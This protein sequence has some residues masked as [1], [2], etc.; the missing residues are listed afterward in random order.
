[1]NTFGPPRLALVRGEGAHVWDEQGREY[2]DFFGGI[3]VN[4]LGHN[5]PAL[6]EAVTTQL[7]TL[8]HVSNFFTSGPQVELAERLL[9]LVAGDGRVFFSNSGT[10]AN[11]AAL[12]LTRRTGRTG[13]WRWRA[14]STAA[15]WAPWRS[16]RRLPTA[17]RSSRCPGTSRSCPTATRPRSLPPSTRPRRRSSS[18]RCR[19]RPAWSCRPPASCRPPR[20]TTA[21]HGALLWVDEVQTGMGRTGEWLAHTEAGIVPD[22]VTLAK[23]LGGG[24]PI[25]AMIALGGAATLLEPGN[26]G[27]T[28]GGNPV[29]CAAAL[30]VIETIEK[31]GLLEAAVTR[32]EQLTQVLLLGRRLSAVEGRGLLLGAQLATETGRRG[33]LPRPGA[34]LPAQQHRTGA[35]ALRPAADDHRGRH[36][37]PGQRWAAA[38]D[39]DGR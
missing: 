16:P 20:E 10:E 11:E 17:S 31:E 15:P 27:T 22:I 25:G 36:R 33:G 7:R 19:A 2:V 29:A 32:G 12:K 4:A 18:S 23:G 21:Q 28:F 8:G 24:I 5:H 35:A 39:G 3:A 13:S 30:A 37:V 14:P 34:R 6:V 38:R 1:M 9:A 26:H